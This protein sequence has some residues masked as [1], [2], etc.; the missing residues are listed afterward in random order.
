MIVKNNKFQSKDKYL[1][2][3]LLLFIGLNAFLTHL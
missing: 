2:N 1:N 3:V